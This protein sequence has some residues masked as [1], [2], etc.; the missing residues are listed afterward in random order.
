MVGDFT[1]RQW[2]RLIGR[3]ILILASPIPLGLFGAVLTELSVCDGAHNA[4][5]LLGFKSLDVAHLATVLTH[6]G[7]LIL[8]TIWP[9]CFLTAVR[10]LMSWNSHYDQPQ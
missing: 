10:I 8:I 7:P 3:L 5:Y 2:Q 4:C 9:I 1:R 6:A